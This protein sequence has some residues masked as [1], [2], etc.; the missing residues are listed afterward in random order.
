[1]NNNI[2]PEER[3]QKEMLPREYDLLF[4]TMRMSIIEID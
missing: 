2:H 3:L 1:M 4:N